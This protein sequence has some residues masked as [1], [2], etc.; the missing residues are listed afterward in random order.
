MRDKVVATATK[1]GDMAEGWTNDRLLADEGR[2]QR[3]HGRQKE[4]C[5][6]RAIRLSS[7]IRF[8]SL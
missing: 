3:R 2:D 8:V 1:V 6:L 7:P 5:L 4:S